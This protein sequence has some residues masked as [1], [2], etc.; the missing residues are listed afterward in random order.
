MGICNCC[1]DAKSLCYQ[2]FL[3]KGNLLLCIL[4]LP[5]V[6][7]VRPDPDFNS[8]KKDYSYSNVQSN[9]PSRSSNGNSLLFPPR[10]SKNWLV[11]I[12]KPAIGVITKPQV[13]DYCV[14]I[15]AN[16]LGK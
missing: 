10:N 12:D 1:W 8:M 9:P 11:R 6:L 4:G 13:V 15:L 14:Q 2:D 16:V 5:G 3:L 7:S